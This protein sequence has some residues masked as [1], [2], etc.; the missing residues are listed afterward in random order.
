[1]ASQKESLKA[2]AAAVRSRNEAAISGLN[3][4]K[5]QLS[6]HVA[7]IQG[8]QTYDQRVKNNSNTVNVQIV[9]NGLNVQQLANRVVSQVLKE[10]GGG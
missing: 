1:M 2:G 3:A 10:L 5:T 8:T 6:D 9:Q 7:Y 4:S